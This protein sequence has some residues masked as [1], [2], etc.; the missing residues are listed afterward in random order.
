M[1]KL[2]KE[3]VDSLTFQPQLNTHKSQKRINE[4]VKQE[5]LKA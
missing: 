5:D 2:L 4:K 3:E 1:Q